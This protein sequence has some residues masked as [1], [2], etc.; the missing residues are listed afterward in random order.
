MSN[1]KELEVGY[2][3]YADDDYELAFKTLSAHEKRGSPEVL[4][5]LGMMYMVGDPVERDTEKAE[6][7]LL[8]SS[9][10]GFHQATYV[11]GHEYRNDDYIKG[12]QHL[13]LEF[14]QRAADGGDP[15][16]LEEMGWYYLDGSPGVERDHKK[17][18]KY[19]RRAGKETGAAAYPLALMYLKGMGTEQD[20]FQSYSWAMVALEFR[21]RRVSNILDQLQGELSRTEKNEATNL[22]VERFKRILVAMGNR[23]P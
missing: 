12:K 8:R 21:D 4:Y 10:G 19:F 13:A 11:L 17:A 9:Q 18:L 15:H 16:G 2:Q 6:Q 1:S 14:F 3:A 23:P 22:S 5:Y 20:F 7:L